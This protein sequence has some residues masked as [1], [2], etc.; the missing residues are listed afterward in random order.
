[1][2]VVCHEYR[3]VQVLVGVSSTPQLVHRLDM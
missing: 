2:I 3:V 1:V